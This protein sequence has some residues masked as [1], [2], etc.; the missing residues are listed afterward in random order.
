MLPGREFEA[1]MNREEC[2]DVSIAVP[3]WVPLR[4]VL[5][6]VLGVPAHSSASTH[7]SHALMK[8]RGTH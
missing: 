8:P 6:K 1:G 5:L 4:A 3:Q 7:V 2:K